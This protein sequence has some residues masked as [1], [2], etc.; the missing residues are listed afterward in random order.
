[1]FGFATTFGYF[2]PAAIYT[3]ECCGQCSLGIKKTP[4]GCGVRTAWTK[5]VVDHTFQGGGCKNTFQGGSLLVDHIHKGP[6]LK[7]DFQ[8]FEIW[9]LNSNV[10]L[11]AIGPETDFTLE[12]D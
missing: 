12:K 6:P 7:V 9:S 10:G 1:M 2:D 5:E 11:D 4:S 8:D 3:D